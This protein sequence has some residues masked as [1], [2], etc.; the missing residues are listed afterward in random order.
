MKLGSLIIV[1]DDSYSRTLL[2]TS[3]KAV[4]FEIVLSTSTATESFKPFSTGR[5][6]LALID[7]D[8]GRGPNGKD[9]AYK[10]RE[11]QHDIG[12][13]LITSFTDHRAAGD[14][15]RTLPIGMRHIT[16]SKLEDMNQ[17]V[18]ILLL[19]KS[20]PLS[21]VKVQ[22]TKES[23]L[24]DNQIELLRLINMGF[25]NQEIARQLQ[26]TVSGVEKTISRINHILK[27]EGDTALNSRIALVKYFSKLTGKG[28]VN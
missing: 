27:I 7:L 4:G 1:D 3:L 6:D 10:M 8:L 23:P 26:I 12:L 16:K 15:W 17:L 18:R 9:V 11:L 20:D 21:K 13:V 24:T 2:A 14:P 25:S 5:V 22:R 28:Q 19:A